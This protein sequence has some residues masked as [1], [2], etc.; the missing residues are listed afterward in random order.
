MEKYIELL[1]DNMDLAK[2]LFVDE[3]GKPIT[4]METPL[5]CGASLGQLERMLVY[6]CGGKVFINTGIKV[7]VE[8]KKEQRLGLFSKLF[9]KNPKA[10]RIP[11]SDGEAKLEDL[12]PFLVYAWQ[13]QLV[14]TS[15]AR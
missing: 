1:R 3:T 15:Q 12:K 4:D 14:E 13:L 6:T 5:V 7:K 10:L 11:K 9:K 8:P 2:D